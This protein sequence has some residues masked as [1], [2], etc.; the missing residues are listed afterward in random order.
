MTP[1]EILATTAV[2]VV[3]G[4]LGQ[5]AR[6]LLGMLPRSPN[7]QWTPLVTGLVLAV[8]VGAVAGGLGS[9]TFLGDSITSQDL[10]ALAALGYLGTD[11]IEQLVKTKF[12]STRAQ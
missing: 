7:L 3:F 8:L 5:S 4:V 12:P 11:A 6:F 1:G 2:G 9:V 10:F